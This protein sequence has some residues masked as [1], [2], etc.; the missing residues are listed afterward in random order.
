MF[1]FW[2]WRHA[3]RLPQDI[4]K[5]PTYLHQVIASRYWLRH[6][7]GRWNEGNP[8]MIRN[9][10]DYVYGVSNHQHIDCLLS[11][12]SGAHQRKY[13]RSASLAFV[14]GIHR[15]PVDS[16]PNVPVT[17]KIFPFY[18]I[19]I[20]VT[21][22]DCFGIHSSIVRYFSMPLNICP[23]DFTGFFIRIELILFQHWPGRCQAIIWP[24]DSKFTDVYMCHLALMNY[25]W[26]IHSLSMHKKPS[27]K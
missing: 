25:S 13:W 19:I 14:R 11:R 18:D 12:F 26:T 6:K 22:Y 27:R 3:P 21:D 5:R 17:R 10:R 1:S 4:Y 24:N 16:P 9:T 15:S 2:D 20:S 8:Y 23:K 7:Y